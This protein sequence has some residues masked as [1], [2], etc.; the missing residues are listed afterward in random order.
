MQLAN[1]TIEYRIDSNGFVQANY[2][3]VTKEYIEDNVGETITNI[4]EITREGISQAGLVTGYQFTPK[5]YASAQYYHDMNENIAIEW[6]ANLRYKDDC[7]YVG[8]TYSNELRSWTGSGYSD[9]N[10][11]PVY[12]N[13][14]SVNFGIVGFGTSA[15]SGSNISGF[16]S[17]GNSLE[18]GRP[19]FLNN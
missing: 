15:G 4:D 17:S 11:D 10:A 14:F 7:W 18:Y 19:F 2:R 5:W 13:N 1:S 3:Y 9:I 16:D 8:V 6:L 12:E